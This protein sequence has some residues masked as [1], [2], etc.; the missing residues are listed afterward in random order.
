MYL[1]DWDQTTLQA[2][3]PVYKKRCERDGLD[4]ESMWLGEQDLEVDDG[5][6]VSIEMPTAIV[7]RPLSEKDQDDRVRMALGLTS[8][9]P[10]PEVSEGT[11]LA[12]YHY[13]KDKLKFPFKAQSVDDGSSLTVH[14]LPDPDEYDLDEEVGLLAEART[15]EGSF[16]VPLTDLEEAKGNRKLV[17]DYG[18]WFFESR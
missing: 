3:H 11:L 13:L 1:I 18:C 14:R 9:D 8:D 17:E 15:R 16:D 6:A 12:Y 7:T 2:I 5:A 4:P 10:L